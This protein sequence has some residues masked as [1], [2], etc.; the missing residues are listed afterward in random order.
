[1][2]RVMAMVL[3]IKDMLLKRIDRVLSWQQRSQTIDSER[4]TCNIQDGAS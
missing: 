3:V 2:K 4:S 1:M